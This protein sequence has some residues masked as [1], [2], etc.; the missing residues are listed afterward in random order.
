MNEIPRNGFLI[1]NGTAR[2]YGTNSEGAQKT[3]AY[4]GVGDIF[5]G[6][7][8]MGH[9]K[10]SLYF[11]ESVSSMELVEFG[12]KEF[13]KEIESNFELVQSILASVSLNHFGFFISH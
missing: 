10:S 1:L 12:C 9:S 2:F 11:C 7:C 5:P 6:E 4:A 13:K 3:V 8:L